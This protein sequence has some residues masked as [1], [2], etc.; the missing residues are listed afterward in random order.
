MKKILIFFY[1]VFGCDL[2]ASDSMSRLIERAKAGNSSS[3]FYLGFYYLNESGNK[4]SSLQSA[5]Y[6]LQESAR[7]GSGPAASLL[8]QLYDIG[9]L[10]EKDEIKAAEWFQLG[11]NLKDP[12]SQHK[13]GLYHISGRGG[14]NKDIE[15]G[16]NLLKS[17]ADQGYIEAQVSLGI[18]YIRDIEVKA[19]FIEANRLFKLAAE[20]GDITAMR[21]LSMGYG[22]KDPSPEKDL[23]SFK[24][25]KKAADLDDL[26]SIRILVYYYQYGVGTE[27]SISEALKYLERAYDLGYNDAKYSIA[28]IFLKETD[29]LNV[30]L[31]LGLAA[32]AV[33][34]KN[35]KGLNL[36]GDVYY[37]GEHVKNDS[38]KAHYYYGL[39]CDLG[40]KGACMV[41]K[42][43]ER[44]SL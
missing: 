28:E 38:A 5:L 1:F 32:N 29:Y 22:L 42:E 25:R 14:L 43:I 11:V 27:R 30:T 39:A 36:L 18:L 34:E 10:L 37:Y 21:Q 31:G 26:D 15:K 16:I 2:Y 41:K 23:N 4:A 12:T 3:Q 17:S 7:N 24:W 6:W 35:I 40:D 9:E 33:A 19:D 8:G 44:H 13:L 20:Q